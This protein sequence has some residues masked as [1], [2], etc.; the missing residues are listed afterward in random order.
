MMFLANFQHVNGSF[1]KKRTPTKT[2]D[3]AENLIGE[4]FSLKTC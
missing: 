4:Q 1:M 2:N 3:I